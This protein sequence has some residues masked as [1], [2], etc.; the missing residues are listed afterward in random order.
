LGTAPGVEGIEIHW[1]SGRREVLGP[2]PRGSRLT[3]LEGQGV[4]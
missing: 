3:I 2:G 4:F 1:P